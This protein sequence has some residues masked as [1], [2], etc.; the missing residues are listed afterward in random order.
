MTLGHLQ[1]R[2]YQWSETLLIRPWAAGSRRRA[3]MVRAR[4]RWLRHCWCCFLVVHI[5]CYHR[6][7][8]D[9]VRLMIRPS[10]LLYY[11]SSMYCLLFVSIFL[12]VGFIFSATVNGTYGTGARE[13][14]GCVRLSLLVCLSLRLC[15]SVRPLVLFPSGLLPHYFISRAARGSRCV[16]FNFPCVF[17]ATVRFPLSIRVWWVPWALPIA[18]A[19]P[20][21]SSIAGP[22]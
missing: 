18:E 5:G 16:I 3:S 2:E 17:C 21:F 1:T 7:F 20:L 4:T 8:H 22:S 10:T 19:E 15:L 12:F 14:A 6:R 13:T 9:A 11:N